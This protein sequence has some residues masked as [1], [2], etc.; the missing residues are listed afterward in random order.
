[1]LRFF[2]SAHPLFPVRWAN[3]V[4]GWLLGLRSN[5][6]SITVRN[7][8]TPNGGDDGPSIDVNLAWAKSLI[9]SETPRPE[10]ER[11]TEDLV[12]PEEW[13][14]DAG[15]GKGQKQKTTGIDGE[16]TVEAY[17]CCGKSILPAAAD[18]Q[19]KSNIAPTSESV[20]GAYSEE[21]SVGSS[22]YAA[23]LDHQ[24]PY[25]KADEVS[26]TDGDGEETTV[27]AVLDDLKGGYSGS[28]T[29]AYSGYT[30]SESLDTYLRTKTLTIKDGLITKVADGGDVKIT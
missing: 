5:S 23:R 11:P 26:A 30:N 8:Q 17:P 24:H 19:H 2:N 20:P 29:V 22:A 1:M 16:T 6:G 28:V 12:P 18:H 25:P 14:T 21:G 7:T 15:D 10:T 3:A 13:E 4:T 9:A 27:Q